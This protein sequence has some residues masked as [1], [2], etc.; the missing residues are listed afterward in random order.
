M[1]QFLANS[2]RVEVEFVRRVCEVVGLVGGRELELV[3]R[4]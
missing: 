4:C 2:M 3:A 1:L